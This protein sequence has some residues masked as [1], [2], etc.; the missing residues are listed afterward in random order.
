MTENTKPAPAETSGVACD[1]CLKEIPE[2]VA[3]SSEGDDYTQH[4][5]GLECYKKWRETGTEK[6]EDATEPGEEPGRLTS[7]VR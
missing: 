5:C 3:V 1:V 4:F 6:Q 2:S 7:S